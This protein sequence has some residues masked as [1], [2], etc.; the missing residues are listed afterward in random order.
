MDTIDFA[1]SFVSRGRLGSFA[2]L[3]GCHE[4]RAVSSATAQRPDSN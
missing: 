1:S 4:V 2:M 3:Q